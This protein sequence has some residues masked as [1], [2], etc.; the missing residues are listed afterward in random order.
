MIGKTGEFLC[1]VLELFAPLGDVRSRR[2][3]GGYG[4]FL[5]DSMFALITKDEELFLKADDL[6]RPAFEHMG[7]RPYGKMPYYAAPTDSLKDW[8][9]IRS[10]AQGAVEASLRAKASKPARRQRDSR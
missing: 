4:I 6:N 7:L 3:F 9:D 8:E 10:W 2:M 5:N 1:R